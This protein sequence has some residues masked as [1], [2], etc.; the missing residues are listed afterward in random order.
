MKKILV[1]LFCLGLAGCATSAKLI[2]LQPPTLIPYATCPPKI[3][4]VSENSIA[5]KVGLKS[6]DI[7]KEVDGQKVTNLLYGISKFSPPVKIGRTTIL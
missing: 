3:S 6:G 2:N 1:L 7:I 5:D 4:Y